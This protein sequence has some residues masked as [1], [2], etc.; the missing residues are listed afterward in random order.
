M[1][2]S[3]KKQKTGQKFVLIL[4]VH[5]CCRMFFQ[6][7]WVKRMVRKLFGV[8]LSISEFSLKFLVPFLH[9][10]HQRSFRSDPNVDGLLERASANYKWPVEPGKCSKGSLGHPEALHPLKFK[11]FA[12]K[13]CGWKTILSYWVPVTFQG[14]VLKLPGRRILFMLLL[15][16]FFVV[17]QKCFIVQPSNPKTKKRLKE[18]KNVWV[19][20]LNFQGTLFGLVI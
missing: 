16:A 12:L 4:D 13:N 2:F 20:L 19:I 18:C 7:F 8:F 14:R 6:G 3:P 10:G 9:Q 1:F 5:F 11:I 15:L 17:G